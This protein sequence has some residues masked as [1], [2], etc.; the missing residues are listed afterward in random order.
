ML[1]I[2]IRI[3]E[4]VYWFQIEEKFSKQLKEREKKFQEQLQQILL[5]HQNEL[6]EH[7]KKYFTLFNEEQIQCYKREEQL[8]NELDFLKKSFH[9][10]K[11]K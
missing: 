8:R 1:F 6:K 3:N 2:I 7:E 11:V 10:Y 4:N 5:N 9:T